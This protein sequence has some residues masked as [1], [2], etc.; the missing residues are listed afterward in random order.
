MGPATLTCH[1]TY[2]SCLLFLL[3]FLFLFKITRLI[4]KLQRSLCWGS[5]SG[6]SANG[7]IHGTEWVYGASC[8]TS[9]HTEPP[10]E[11]RVLALLPHPT[12]TSLSVW[13][14]SFSFAGSALIYASYTYIVFSTIHI[15]FAK[16]LI[17]GLSTFSPID[18]HPFDPTLKSF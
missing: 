6:S 12:R 16:S 7:L 11:K 15:K 14:S 5:P 18:S 4:N 1:R 13:Y 8:L 10:H 2:L 9:I 3:Y 17:S